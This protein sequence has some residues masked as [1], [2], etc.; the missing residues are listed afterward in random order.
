MPDLQLFSSHDLSLW[1][2]KQARQNASGQG[3]SVYLDRP[4]GDFITEEVN[5]AWP[6]RPSMVPAEGTQVKETER[7]NLEMSIPKDLIAFSKKATELDEM[8]KLKLYEDRVAC[9]GPTKAKALTSAQNLSVLYKPMLKEGGMNKD[10][11]QQYPDTVRGKVDGWT[12]CIQKLNFVE[13]DIGGQK[14]K[15][16]EDCE[17]SPRLVSQGLKSGDTKFF[18]YL[19]KNAD[20]GKERYT[21][22]LP[23]VDSSGEKRLRY[24]G[25]QDCKRG[26][27]VCVVFRISK[28]YITETAGPTLSIKEVYIKSLPNKVDVKV[29]SGAELV[30]ESELLSLL[31]SA[32]SIPDCSAESPTSPTLTTPLEKLSTC[33]STVEENSSGKH[34]RNEIELEFQEI[35][36]QASLEVPATPSATFSTTPLVES[37]SFLKATPSKKKKESS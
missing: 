12:S 9:F 1:E 15:M 20:T 36:P 14:T 30:D 33:D 26:S 13:K 31:D 32:G 16:V 25:P 21:D 10:G 7:L 29:M 18:M 4:D 22:R 34:K 17:W 6:I 37:A 35:S 23:F 27:K 8:L 11:T 19:G 24:V 3:K 2:V 5:V 28:V